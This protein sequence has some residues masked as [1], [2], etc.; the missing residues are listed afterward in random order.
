MSD[1]E[2]ATTLI[3]FLNFSL[4]SCNPKVKQTAC[5]VMFNFL[6]TSEPP[7]KKNL[8][9]LLESSIR[10]VEEVIVTPEVTE[11]ETIVASLILLCRLLYKN[12]ELTVWVEEQHNAEFKG[13]LEGLE[14][15][16]QE[17]PAE[18]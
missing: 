9:S 13:S 1:V 6:M 18:V 3:M 2:K 7:M 16:L 12:H 11:K 15:R 4:K 8:H 10:S 14:S 17:M 5:I